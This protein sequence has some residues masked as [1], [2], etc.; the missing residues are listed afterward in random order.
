MNKLTAAETAKTLGITPSRVRQLRIA[1]ALPGK[2]IGRDWFYDRRKV[3][4]FAKIPRTK[5]RK[6]KRK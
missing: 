1:G 3:A 4:A 5:G 2:Q 6:P